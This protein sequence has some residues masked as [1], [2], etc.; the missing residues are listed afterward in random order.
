MSGFSGGL[1]ASESAFAVAQET[2]QP[3][4]V[5]D[6]MTSITDTC[7][8]NSSKSFNLSSSVRSYDITF[9]NTDNSYL[10]KGTILLQQSVGG[11]FAVTYLPEYVNYQGDSDDGVSKIEIGSVG[12]VAP[13]GVVVGLTNGNSFPVTFYIV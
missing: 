12:T 2:S 1:F 4:N 3:S 6:S 7:L 9:E 13:T 10:E 5:T 8:A 11:N